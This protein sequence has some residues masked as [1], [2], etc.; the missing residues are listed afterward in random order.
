MTKSHEKSPQPNGH[1]PQIDAEHLVDDR[2]IDAMLKG[3]YQDTPE[4]TAQRVTRVCRALEVSP[5][6][7]KWHW[8]ASL[9]TA[10]AA[11]VILG[12]TLVLMS[13]QNVQADLAPV[14]AAFDRGD[15]TYSI[16]IGT[17][18]DQP[19]RRRGFGPR[20]FGR[21]PPF[22]SPR[23]GMSAQR[24]DGASLYTRG[25]NYLLTWHSPRG[26]SISKGFDGQDRWLVTPW[27]K[28]RRGQNHSLLQTEI[29][30]HISSLLFLDLRDT[31]HQIQKNYT[32]SGPLLGTLEDGFSEMEYYIAELDDHQNK[33]PRRIELW[34][35][36][37]SNQL[38]QILCTGVPT[39]HPKGSRTNLQINLVNTEPLPENWFTQAAHTQDP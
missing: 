17:D 35:D 22:R 30:D 25:H 11:I 2:L 3:H 18:T 37:A 20:R 33:R 4:A 9:S 12:L 15:K 38:H 1:D 10:A 39:H 13:P 23:R 34:F 6:H 32:L 24:L 27:G 28:S 29:P 26:G 5:R 21:R 14:L 36:I 8:K 16:D 19:V 31:L 7:V